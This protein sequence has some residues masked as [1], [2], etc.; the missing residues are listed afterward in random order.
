MKHSKKN[1]Y[2]M[3]HKL[4]L[5]IAWPLFKINKFSNDIELLILSNFFRQKFSRKRGEKNSYES[6]LSSKASVS[7]GFLCSASLFQQ[8]SDLRL[9]IFFSLQVRKK[10]GDTLTKLF[11]AESSYSSR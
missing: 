10:D 9:N 11:P 3:Y 1:I 4:I 6:K 2:S 7:L 5:G 8:F